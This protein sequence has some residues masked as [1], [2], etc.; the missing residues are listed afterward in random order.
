M[1]IQAK[2]SDPYHKRV[3]AGT[4]QTL[5]WLWESV[6]PRPH[7][8]EPKKLALAIVGLGRTGSTSFVSSLKTLGYTP[9]H[10]DEG[11]EAADL[12]EAWW[13]QKMSD[14]DFIDALGE[15]GFDAPFIPVHRFVELVARRS[16]I[17]V[18]LTMRDKTR[19][20]ESFIPIADLPKINKSRP[21]KWLKPIQQ[22]QSF[23]EEI[24]SVPIVD[25]PL[26]EFSSKS[27]EQKV[28]ILAEGYDR[29]VEF[30]R[31]TVPSDRL[32]EYSVRDG[33]DPICNFVGQPVPD[34]PFPH[35]NDRVV[36]SSFFRTLKIITWTWPLIFLLL[37]IF[38]PVFF[39][40]ALVAIAFMS[41][42]SFLWA[43]V[44]A[45]FCWGRKSSEEADE[46]LTENDHNSGGY[47][48]TNTNV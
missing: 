42:F 23:L 3:Y 26:E 8:R 22:I 33:W 2:A 16:E 36:N 7:V 41:V 44:A 1:P 38:V 35:I 37:L 46:P 32:L 11:Q 12:Y 29:W 30:V 39:V 9:L 10:D 4:A 15:R 14:D 6:F 40:I 27:K 5:V 19:W 21:F 13:G 47:K 48:S 24:T 25:I 28:E 45:I 20:A 31:K 43:C 17:K 34:E 18:V